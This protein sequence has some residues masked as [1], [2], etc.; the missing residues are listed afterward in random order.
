MREN[1]SLYHVKE[2]IS[3]AEAEMQIH[4]HNDLKVM[5]RGGGTYLIID[6]PFDGNY[7]VT[8]VR[9]IYQLYSSLYRGGDPTVLV[10]EGESLQNIIEH[11]ESM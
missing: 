6:T 9:G 7:A 4:L 2:V 10:W 8:Y 3:K 5:L 11:L 1:V